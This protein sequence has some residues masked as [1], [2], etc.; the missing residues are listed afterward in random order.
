VDVSVLRGSINGARVGAS[1]TMAVHCGCCV[2]AACRSEPAII[3]TEQAKV[4][5]AIRIR[6]RA[7]RVVFEFG[8]ELVIAQVVA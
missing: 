1:L 3:Q 5:A 4:D 7:N 2:H 6:E 8:S